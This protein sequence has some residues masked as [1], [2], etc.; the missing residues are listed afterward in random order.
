MFRLRKSKKSA[1]PSIEPCQYR[2]ESVGRKSVMCINCKDCVANASLKN[3]R[4]R[5][6]VLKALA[7]MKDEPLTELVLRKTFYKV[8]G[9]ET[10]KALQELA[11]VLK[12]VENLKLCSQCKEVFRELWAD[13]LF[14]YYKLASQKCADCQGDLNWA[15]EK[16][17]KTRLVKLSLRLGSKDEAYIRMFKPALVPEIISSYINTTMPEEKPV[18]EY[19]VADVRISIH[20]S[21]RLDMYYFIHFP[22]LELTNQEMKL[23]NRAFEK[24]CKHK[25]NIEFEPHTIRKEFRHIITDIIKELAKEVKIKN[26]QKLIEI[27]Y[28]HTAGYGT[29]EPI[30]ADESVQ[31]VFVDSGSS[32]VHVVHNDF[33][34]CITNIYMTKDEIDKLSARLRALSGRPFDASTPVLHTELEDFGVRVCGI[35][36][37]STYRGTGFAFRRRKSEPWTLPEFISV[38]MLDSK[39]AGLLSFLMDSQNSILVTGP[40]SSGKTSL[41]TSLL[42]E[43]PQNLRII[44][45]EDT[46]EIPVHAL[47]KMGFKI[48]HL[49]TEAFAKGFELST[50]DALRTSLRLGDSVLVIGEVRGPEAKTLFEA[51]RIGAT[52]N[53]VLGTI[54]GSN[55]RDTWDRVVNDLGVPSTSFKAVDLVLTAGTIRFGDNIRRFRRLLDVSEVSSGW[56]K[57]PK[58]RTLSAYY[59]PSDS[60]KT[61]FSRSEKLSKSARI[62]GL[63]SAKVRESIL[64]RARMKED[65]CRLA[66]KLKRPE[67]MGPEWVVAA[68]NQYFRLAS[69]TTDYKKVYREWSKWLKKEAGLKRFS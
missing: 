8:Y 68:N 66:K 22:E 27:L 61:A 55:A 60:W 57:E 14:V 38:K 65:L 69:S 58:F 62:K 20:P 59:R 3:P 67:L 5:E 21:E 51:M 12:K 25:K 17:E 54:H 53:V 49:K 26:T 34:E 10:L 37:P 23:L 29:I 9:E 30:L 40:R 56:I 31:D 47:K 35:C 63:T 2:I 41:L 28:R 13:P 52:G 1:F 45:I 24:L 46:P 16:L 50:T 36:Q 7:H 6:G 11:D 42:L 19:Q 18:K 44:L 43:I 32:L 48:E 4:C 15:R 39:T 64:V 33:G